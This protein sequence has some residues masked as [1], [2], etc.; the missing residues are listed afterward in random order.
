MSG[1][2]S[3]KTLRFFQQKNLNLVVHFRK[4]NP[5]I[6][7]S[8]IAAVLLSILILSSCV[9]KKN[10]L[11]L[12]NEKDEL[13]MNIEKMRQSLQNQINELQEQ[14]VE[15]TQD[16]VSLNENMVNLET[17]LTDTEE[18]VKEVEFNL[19]EK[20]YQIAQLWNEMDA[21]FTGVEEAMTTSNSRIKELENFLYLDLDE[22][23]GFSSGSDNVSAD[24]TET[25]K[26]IADM[27]LENPAVT[28]VIE[29][30]TDSRPTKSDKYRD[31][32]DLSVSRAT[33]IVR[34]LVE[35]GVNPKQL[36]ASGRGEYMPKVA[37]DENDP[38]AQEANR[39]TEFII[40]PNIGKIYKVYKNRQK[41]NP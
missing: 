10:F 38:E 39:R 7:P 15:L 26:K 2:Q 36:I 11:A 18:K 23:P 20:Q 12:Q 5:M 22:V 21:A 14:N 40:V 29:G 37:N 3:V 4:H 28:M 35:L 32:W 1:L 30:H 31:N 24:D 27:L 8:K 13:A 9:S 16:K 17:Q 6:S 34:K 25:L 19:K 41:T 33:Q